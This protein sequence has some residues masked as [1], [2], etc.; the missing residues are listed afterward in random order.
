VL[1]AQEGK[2]SDVR[3]LYDEMLD[4]YAIASTDDVLRNHEKFEDTFDAMIKQ[5]NECA[6]FIINYAKGSYLR[7]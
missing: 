3:A 1:K 5:S 7:E 6:V 2:D 4:T